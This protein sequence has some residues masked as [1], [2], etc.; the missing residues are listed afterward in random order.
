LAIAVRVT[1]R[2]GRS[3]QLVDVVGHAAEFDPRTV[4]LGGHDRELGEG[5]DVDLVVG[6]MEVVSHPHTAGVEERPVVE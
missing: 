1:A 3:I 5:V 6:K 4:V 2:A